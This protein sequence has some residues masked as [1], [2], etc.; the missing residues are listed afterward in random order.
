MGQLMNLVV[1][2]DCSAAENECKDD[3]NIHDFASFLIKRILKAW[4]FFMA[5]V[6]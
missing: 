3:E 6:V 1:D 5:P 4:V 2:S